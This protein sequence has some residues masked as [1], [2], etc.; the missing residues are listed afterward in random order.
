MVVSEFENKLW[1]K[2][3]NTSDHSLAIVAKFYAFLLL[4]K[5]IYL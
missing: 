4:R 1:L 5:E 2:K 3:E